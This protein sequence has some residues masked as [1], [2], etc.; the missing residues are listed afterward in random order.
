MKKLMNLQIFVAAAAM[1]FVVL[2]PHQVSAAVKTASLSTVPTSDDPIISGGVSVSST[3]VDLVSPLDEKSTRQDTGMGRPYGYTWRISLPQLCSGAK[4]QKVRVV[5]DTVAQNEEPGGG[6]LLGLYDSNGM[7]DNYTIHEGEDMNTWY[8][9]FDAPVVDRG[10]SDGTIFPADLGYSGQLDATWDISDHVA[11]EQL[12]I[13]IQQWLIGDTQAQTTIQSVELTY[14][15]S[16]CAATASADGV[17][18]GRNNDIEEAAPKLVA[19]GVNLNTMRLLAATILLAVC[20][21]TYCAS[22]KRSRIYRLTVD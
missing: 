1:V 9:G 21:V 12:G 2:P 11:G 22:V 6:I 13:Y 18:S 7:I 14:D 4:L 5:T 16:G 8:L 15:D 19:T 20:S 17:N 3:G 10:L